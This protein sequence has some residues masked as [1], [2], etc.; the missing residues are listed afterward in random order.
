[1]LKKG[2]WAFWTLC[3]KAEENPKSKLL[4][5]EQGWLTPLALLLSRKQ[6]S[7]EP[8]SLARR[9]VHEVEQW[10]QLPCWLF[11]LWREKHVKII[12]PHMLGLK[13]V[14]SVDPFIRNVQPLFLSPPGWKVIWPKALCGRNTWSL[15]CWGRFWLLSVSCLEISLQSQNSYP[16]TSLLWKPPHNSI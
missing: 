11:S 13:I 6:H 4:G 16:W 12:H 9:H 5:C 7:G 14:C 2:D 10:D 3:G 1:M 15:K 8:D